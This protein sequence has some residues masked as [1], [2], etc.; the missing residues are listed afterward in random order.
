MS[1][2]DTLN[3]EQRRAVEQ[4]EGPVLILAGA[5]S[6]KTRAL[7]H[8]VAFLIAECGVNPYNILALTF[9]NKAAGEMRERVDRIVGFGAESVWV[10]TF[11]SL[12]VRILRRHAE[13]LGYRDHFV[14]YD[15][16]DS[17]NLLKSICKTWN[18]ER[19]GLKVRQI[20]NAISRA[21]DNLITPADYLSRGENIPGDV[22]IAKAYEEYEKAL[23]DNNA[24]DF[25]D[26]IFNT[27]ELFRREREVLTS[28]QERF[29]YI[30]VDEYQDTNNAQFELIR[31]LA[32]RYRNLCVVGDDDQSIYRFRGANI[33]N[34]LDFEK[35]YPDAEVVYLEQNYRSTGNILKA[36]NAVIRNNRSRKDKALWTEEDE[37]V[38]VR[39]HRFRNAYEEGEFVARE[40]AAAKRIRGEHFNDMAVLYRTNAQSRIVE[41]QF[42]REGIPYTLVGGVNFYA[43]RE[44]KDLL[45]YLRVVDN[46]D[47]DLSVRRIINVPGRGIGATT[48][49]HVDRYAS[50][51][52]L[53]FFEA[54]READK[55]PGCERSVQKLTG[56]V[57]M[58]RIFRTQAHTLS[59][60]KFLKEI[61]STVNYV[62]YLR[63]EDEKDLS[64][65]ND[66]ERNVEELVSKL[67]DYEE[68]N[69]EP[70]LSGF[71]EEVSLIADIDSVSENDDRVLLMTLH[72][73]KGLEFDRVYM[74]GMEENLFP[75][76]MTLEA[77]ATDPAAM[78]EE[79]RLAYVGITRAKRVLTLTAAMERM[80]NGNRCCNDVSR[81]VREIPRELLE[82]VQGGAP[83]A[84]GQASFSFDERDPEVYRE[85][86]PEEIRDVDPAVAR[87]FR[88]AVGASSAGAERSGSRAGRRAV[89]GREEIEHEPGSSIYGMKKRPRAEMG[90]PKNRLMPEVKPYGGRGKSGLAGLTKGMP[91][92][93]V[94]DYAEGDRVT[95]V[96]YGEGTVLT[97]EK[98]PRDTKVTVLFDGCGQKIMYAQFAKLKKI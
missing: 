56:F 37:G 86:A 29:R 70:T 59:L 58:I 48:V 22:L 13:L 50:Q 49:A 92:A 45:A 39:W 21:K 19:E 63:K 88:S 51:N 6:G 16:D 69:E 90:K 91:E 89:S 95:H 79:R 7:T 76:Y 40:V 93:A 77:E 85:I 72:S 15:S 32:D 26:L 75:S 87:A 18:L 35:V 25:D 46:G 61:I 4:T 3:A 9:T 14:I 41:E 23:R 82:D 42:V 38:S 28:Y 17:K 33:R 78:E 81:F 98:G 10:S 55:I 36:A 44:I 52:G 60:D 66:R 2:Y 11:H 43:R 31:L 24:M 34:I 54:L 74:T 1:I 5:G 64:G 80:I 67:V 65:D 96:K 30:H 47:D 83:S 12:C 68:K 57:D 97:M 73:A 62:E 8:R 71:L 53:R 20:Q 27:V 94:I 84:G